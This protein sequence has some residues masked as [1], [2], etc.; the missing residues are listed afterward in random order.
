[1]NCINLQWGSTTKKSF[2]WILEWSI[3]HLWSWS[4]SWPSVF[5]IRG[6]IPRP[7]G[8]LPPNPKAGGQPQNL[9]RSHGQSRRRRVVK[10]AAAR[11][12]HGTPSAEGICREPDIWELGINPTQRL[13]QRLWEY[14]ACAGSHSYGGLCQAD[15]APILWAGSISS[16][17]TWCRGMTGW[18]PFCCCY[19]T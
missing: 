13:V 14:R 8:P 3:W 12:S 17:K 6:P 19:S 9:H 7:A 18:S 16:C 10:H 2:R 11:Q 4:S 1:M 15:W 5:S